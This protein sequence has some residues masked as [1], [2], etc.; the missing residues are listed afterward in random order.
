MVQVRQQTLI[1]AQGAIDLDRWLM[2]LPMVLEDRGP[3]TIAGWLST[4]TAGPTAIG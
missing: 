3:A 2:Q 1:D 4:G